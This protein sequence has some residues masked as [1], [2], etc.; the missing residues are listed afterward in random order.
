MMAYDSS[1]AKKFYVDSIWD[2]FNAR[3][4]LLSDV[5]H[6]FEKNLKW[7][8]EKDFQ[9]KFISNLIQRFVQNHLYLYARLLVFLVIQALL[10]YR[11]NT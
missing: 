11:R 5:I 1:D 4:N 9:P 3:A 10:K 8:S 2:N 6:N 7:K